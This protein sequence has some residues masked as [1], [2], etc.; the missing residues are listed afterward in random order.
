MLRLA[1]TH[2]LDVP[3]QWDTILTMIFILYGLYLRR[4]SQ[5]RKHA[6]FGNAQ[7]TCQKNIKRAF[8]V[9]AN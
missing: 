6:E 7:Q 5:I 8:G 2:Q 3:T 1:T 9:F 4:P